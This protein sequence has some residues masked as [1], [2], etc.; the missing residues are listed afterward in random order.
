M[1]VRI[2]R[3]RAAGWRMPEGAIYVGRPSRGGNPYRVGLVA[4]GCRSAG[5]C[6]HNVLR[7]ETAKEA[8]EAYRDWLS[9]WSPERLA[10]FLAELRDHDL[11]CWCPIGRPCH[12]DVLHELANP[13]EIEHA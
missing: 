4:C 12:A 10:A 8:V 1:P 9:A 3:K 13:G 2:Q 11:A 6:T 5:E 7:V